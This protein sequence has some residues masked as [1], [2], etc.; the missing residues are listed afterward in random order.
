LAKQARRNRPEDAK[1]GF[2]AGTR[3]FFSPA[4]SKCKTLAA[5]IYSLYNVIEFTTLAQPNTP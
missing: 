1:A 3:L 5:F 4:R 2:L